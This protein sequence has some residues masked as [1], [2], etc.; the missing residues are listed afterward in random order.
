[1]LPG[2]PMSLPQLLAVPLNP[3]QVFV[4]LFKFGVGEIWIGLVNG[5]EIFMSLTRNNTLDKPI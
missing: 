4:N 3:S 1:M 5:G 2:E